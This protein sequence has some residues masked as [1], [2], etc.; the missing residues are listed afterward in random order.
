MSAVFARSARLKMRQ[1]NAVDCTGT[2]KITQQFRA[3]IYPLRQMHVLDS[4]S[5]ILRQVQWQHFLSKD[6]QALE[7][8][9]K[10]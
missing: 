9:F 8:P 3:S 2:A 5:V 7:A 1:V 4:T 10:L 6:R